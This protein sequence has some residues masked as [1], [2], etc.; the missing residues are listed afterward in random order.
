MPASTPV[1]DDILDELAAIIRHT[2]K[3]EY[4]LPA[5]GTFEDCA[6]KILDWYIVVPRD[7][8]DEKRVRQ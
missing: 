3:D 2:Y 7:Q 8:V 4:G 1:S 5:D 6:D